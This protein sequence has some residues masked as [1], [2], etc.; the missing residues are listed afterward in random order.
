MRLSARNTHLKNS[1]DKITATSTM[2][3]NTTGCTAI[4]TEP[5]TVMISPKKLSAMLEKGSGEVLAA[6][7]VAVFCHAS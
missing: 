3:I 6:S 1:T 7:R 5:A 2:P 4:S